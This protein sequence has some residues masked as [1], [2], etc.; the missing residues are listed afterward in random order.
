MET[1]KVLVAMA[2]AADLYASFPSVSTAAPANGSA[3]LD[4][5]RENS[6]AQKARVFCYNRR[7]A[8]FCTGAAANVGRDRESIATIA[9]PAVSCTGEAVADDRPVLRLTAQRLR[10]DAHASPRLRGEVESAKQ[11]G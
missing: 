9:G 8:G 3:I 11:T 6:L 7:T 2:A 1:R 5:M 10:A 4:L